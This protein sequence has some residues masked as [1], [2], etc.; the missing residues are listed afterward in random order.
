MEV[1]LTPEVYERA[2][3]QDEQ[4]FTQVR[5]TVNEFRGIEYLHVRKYFLNFEGDFQASND[6]VA[7]PLEVESTRELF[8]AVAEVISLAEAREFIEEFF[9]DVI[10]EIYCK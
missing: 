10:R 1:A 7:I 8:K 9:G 2:I 5:L 6:G 3:W 4:G